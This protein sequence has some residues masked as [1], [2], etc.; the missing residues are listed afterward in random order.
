MSRSLAIRRALAIVVLAIAAGCTSAE[1]QANIWSPDAVAGAAAAP[2]AAGMMAPAPT[3]TGGST[4]SVPN[5]GSGGVPAGSGGAAGMTDV[6][7]GTGGCADVDNTYDAIQIA[8]FEKH[9]CT[10]DSCHG[11]ALQGGLDLRAG[12]SYAS[13]FQVKAQGSAQMRIQPSAPQE[14]YLYLKLA[15]ATLPGS[16]EISNSPMPFGLPALSED[17]LEAVRLWILGGAPETGSVGDPT[18]FGSTDAIARG[19]NACLPGA[20]PIRVA[21]LEPPLASEGIQFRS[22][23]WELAAGAERE[24]CVATYYDLT[25]VIPAERKSPDGTMFYA[26]G[27]RLRQDPGS[28]HYVISNPGIDSTWA[29][30]PAFGAW[31]CAGER[32]GEACDPLVAS[33]CGET[34]VCASAKVDTLGCF[35]FGPLVFGAKDLLGAGLIENVQAAQQYLPPREGVYRELPIKGFLYHDV[36]G[37]NVTSEAATLQTRL[38]IFFATDRVRRLEQR[39]DY[40][41]VQLPA[42][43]PPFTEK[44]V[45]ANHIAPLG[46]ELIRL[47]THMHKRGKRFWVTDPSGAMIYENFL[48]S[49]PLYKEY[50]PGIVF[51]GA[52]D[53]SRTLRACA[54]YNNGVDALG[55]PDPETVTRYSRLPDRTLCTPIACVAG[56][57]GA[58]CNGATDHAT[59]D[60][61]A[62]AGDG[63][64]DA[65]PITPGPTTEDEMFVVMP[66]YILPEGQ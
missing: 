48:Y 55:G 19:L 54:T 59:C 11:S 57:I 37:F 25:N 13:L 41:N 52:T 22:P 64:C 26:N 47:T 24:F 21:P 58:A 63:I 39:I 3:V 2:G 50:D 53:A 9:G 5:A 45:C 8:V 32:N 18:Q 15:A 66:W 30:N 17:E 46:A 38:N 12:A 43:T 34:G 35:G 28:H 1:P 27:S 14:S 60:S 23:P 42:G 44:T 40:A 29:T 62:G 56:K 33:S 16:V 31:T 65:C 4:G 20:D 51:D 36:H 61:T 6:D 49:D 10:A 7:A